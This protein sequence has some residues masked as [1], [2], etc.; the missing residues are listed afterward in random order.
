V[1]NLA[2]LVFVPVALDLDRHPATTPDAGAVVREPLAQPFNL[3]QPPSGPQLW[4]V[5][6]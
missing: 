6:Q 2:N 3:L 4:P 1:A 5:K